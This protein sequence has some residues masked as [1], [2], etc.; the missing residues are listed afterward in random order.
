MPASLDRTDRSILIGAGILVLILAVATSVLTPSRRGGRTGFPSSYSASW[1]GAKAAYILLGELGYD[2]R[3]WDKSP[4]ELGD[5]PQNQVLILTNPL[6][7][8]TSEE[9]AAFRRFLERG[10]RIL[11]T[12]DDVSE[13]LP[14]G[15]KFTETDDA[16]GETKFPALLPSPLTSGAP[17]I[18][19]A[20]PSDWHPAKTDQLAVYGNKDTAAVVT[21]T[22]GKGTIV[23]WGS[24]SPLTN[25]GIKEPGNLP[26][27]LNSLGE[28]NGKRILWDEYYHGA[29]GDFWSYIGKTPLPWVIAQLG[30]LFAFV[31]V[32]YSRRY[33]TIR[34]PR[35]VSRLS[36]LEF[37]DTLGDLYTSA[38]AGSAAVRV[39]CQRLRYQLTRQLGL[40]AN[41]TVSEL[42][43]VSSRTLGWDEQSLLGT[44][45]RADRNSRSLNVRDHEALEIV[46]DL[47]QYAARLEIR[48]AP[49]KKGQPE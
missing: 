47:H 27:L 15:Q 35:K 36:P 16:E 5:D 22:V 43:R 33:G 29:R 3:R 46:Q 21:Y 40:T 7:P 14:G 31:L 32:T 11:A 45:A 9:T 39:A 24:P 20:T 13:F 30:L 1:D 12:G 6:E 42:A 41:A 4:A 37:V 34:M 49:E 18:S 17:E 44:L 28:T 23:W 25:R 48:N 8:A 10:G 2:V 38:H 26:L 19:M